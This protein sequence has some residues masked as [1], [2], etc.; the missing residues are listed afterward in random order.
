M[1]LGLKKL[2]RSTSPDSST[3]HDA[4]NGCTEH[5]QHAPGECIHNNAWA[6]APGFTNGNGHAGTDSPKSP[7]S[8]AAPKRNS[9][10]DNVVGRFTRQ[11]SNADHS[12]TNGV[13]NRAPF[14]DDPGYT[15]VANDPFY[16][17]KA[18]APLTTNT[19]TN[20]NN[21]NTSAP[22]SFRQGTSPSPSPTSPHAKSL[23]SG[24][25]AVRN[26]GAGAGAGAG[27]SV[28]RSGTVGGTFAN[29]P[30]TSGPN[31]TPDLGADF[32]QKRASAEGALDEKTRK[33]L[34]KQEGESEY[35]DSRRCYS[36][37]SSFFC[38]QLRKPSRW[39]RS[40]RVKVL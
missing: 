17:V 27:A 14:N 37:M 9:I 23:A 29:G 7:D 13:N 28:K 35:S 21:N 15:G 36:L 16:S 12:A 20:T 40:S 25:T 33:S 34:I 5:T 32:T 24:G 31:A 6:G 19:Y 11:D 3:F 4:D 26:I 8:P 38:L 10:H 39:R 22:P 30:G 18:P 1:V 2:H